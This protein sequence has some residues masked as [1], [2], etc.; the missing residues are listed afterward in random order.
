VSDRLGFLA[1]VCRGAFLGFTGRHSPLNLP[2]II[3]S[4]SCGFD[5]TRLA[6]GQEMALHLSGVLCLAYPHAVHFQAIGS[7]FRGARIKVYLNA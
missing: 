1:R 5:R 7:A 4:T 2:L 6:K 3:G